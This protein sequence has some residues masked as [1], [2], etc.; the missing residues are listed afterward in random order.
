M[1]DKIQIIID[2]VNKSG[3]EFDEVQAD[4]KG[5][6]R[7]SDD[8]STGMGG[9]EGAVTAAKAVIGAMAVKELAQAAFELGELGAAAE[10]T[11]HAFMNISGGA[12]AAEANLQAMRTATRGAV[13]DTE[14]MQQA[15]R[16]LQM[17]L[18]D[19]AEELGDFTEMAVRLG[20]AMGRDANQSIEEFALLMANQSIPRLD[21]FGI[22]ASNVRMRIKELQAATEDMTR[23]QAFA[24]AVQEEGAKAMDN[25]GEAVEDNALQIERGQAAWKNFRVELGKNFSNAAGQAAGALGLLLTDVTEGLA[26]INDLREG[27]GEAATSAAYFAERYGGATGALDELNS[28]MEENSAVNALASGQ[29]ADYAAM[30]EQTAEPVRGLGHALG[31]NADLLGATSTYAQRAKEEYGG[32]SESAAAFAQTIRENKEAQAE[33]ARMLSEQAQAAG[34]LAARLMD[35]SEAQIAESLIGMLDPQEMGADAYSA[36]V[37]EIGISF[38]IMDEK[39]IALADTLPKVAQAIEEGIVPT[40]QADEALSALIQDAEDGVVNFESLLE[41]FENTPDAADSVGAAL[42]ENLNPAVSDAA[43]RSE[44]AAQHAAAFADALDRWPSEKTIDLNFN[45]NTSGAPPADAPVQVPGV[46]DIA[47]ASGG[48]FRATGPTTLLVGEGGRA[49][50]V[51]VQPVGGGGASNGPLGN[52]TINVYGGNQHPDVI[53]NSVLRKLRDQGLVSRSMT[54][55]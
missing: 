52:V 55:R 28:R 30:A 36:A 16:L 24:I 20:T 27:M 12:A 29:M 38:G 1:A 33:H 7:S 31:E 17:G 26:Q 37:Q 41:Q 6:E 43:T 18:A 9:L 2:A 40:E 50:D 46:P 22:S 42:D 51:F 14:L 32:A 19:N 4:L 34:E 10:R 44:L 53:A 48:A 21:T 35:A 25:L 39:S 3:D 47:M 49:E 5:M 15:A 45:Y 8:A 13:D 54:R 11:E 23:E